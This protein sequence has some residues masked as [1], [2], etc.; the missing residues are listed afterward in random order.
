MLANPA[1]NSTREAGHGNK[2]GGCR[3]GGPRW[4]VSELQMVYSLRSRI[5][6]A[7]LAAL[8]AVAVPGWAASDGA[9]AGRD[10]A[11]ADASKATVATVQ[12]GVR[13]DSVDVTSDSAVAV[14]SDLPFTE[15][16]IANPDIADISTV[17][18]TTLFVLGKRP[19]RTTLMLLDERGEVM[20][21]VNVRVAPDVTELRAR[22][23]ELLPG[24]EVDALTAND[25]IVLTGT[26]G[27]EAALERALELASHYAPGRISNLMTVRQAQDVPAD[28]SGFEARL[29]ALVPG[30][31][32]MVEAANG[33]IVLTGEVDTVEARDHALNLAEVFAPG[34]V[35]DLLAIRTLDMPAPDIG[36]LAAALAEVLPGEDI[37][38]H[39]LGD[40]VVLSGRVTSPDRLDQAMEIARLVANGATITSMLSVQE[41]RSCVVRTRRGGEVV[42]TAI[43]CRED[44]APSSGLAAQP[45]VAPRAEEPALLS[46]GVERGAL[47]PEVSSPST[48]GTGA[49]DN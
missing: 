23:A 46:A 17:S 39:V 22:L 7:S 24:D 1:R 9:G 19:G 37:S 15:L 21:I 38:V 43:P 34:R 16:S 28:L 18:N 6:P 42:E 48:T 25:G 8:V 12:A 32:I 49:G 2:E 13:T 29:R 20:R 47:P 33:A 10:A 30:Q 26:V 31:N 45:R 44:A 5:G 40:A 4:C 14:E 27:S 11:S 3:I 41:A 36:L 35:T